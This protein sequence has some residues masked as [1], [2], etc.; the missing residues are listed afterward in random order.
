[1][2]GF[3]DKDGSMKNVQVIDG[4]SNCTYPVY[5]FTPEE[6]ATLFPAPGQDVEFIEDIQNR[7]AP[8][9]GP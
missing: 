6:F 8:A 4:A 7:R 3:K 2:V 5:A 9:R 1:M